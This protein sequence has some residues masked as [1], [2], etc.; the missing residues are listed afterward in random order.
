MPDTPEL[1]RRTSLFDLDGVRALLYGWAP[2]PA[3]A[4]SMADLDRA[5]AAL[6]AAVPRVAWTGSLDADSVSALLPVVGPSGER[7]AAPILGSSDIVRGD[8]VVAIRQSEPYDPMREALYALYD[9]WLSGPTGVVAER[10]RVGK[11]RS[12]TSTAR[13]ERGRW[14]GDP[15]V[16][17]IIVPESPPPSPSRSRLSWASA[18]WTRRAGSA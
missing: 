4:V 6:F 1:L 15:N 3:A 7:R 14:P 8:R 18:S 17:L 10:V 16:T 12:Y 11:G 2:P 13:Y 5:L 9:R